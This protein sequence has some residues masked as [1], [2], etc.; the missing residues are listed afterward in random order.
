MIFASDMKNGGKSGMFV[1]L[2]VM[3]PKYRFNS[4]FTL[5]ELLVVIA[6]IAILAAMLLPALA[7][8]KERAK[9]IACA[10]NIRQYGLALRMYASDFNDKL[11]SGTISAADKAALGTTW[12]WDLGTNTATL[13]T[14][15]GSV[16][17]IL[18]DPAFSDQN[19]DALWTLSYTSGKS[20]VTGYAATFPDVALGGILGTNYNTTFL[21]AA[22]N[23][24]ERVLLACGTIKS[25]AGAYKG[26][27][28]ATSVLHSTAHM[29]GATPAGGNV[30]ML[31]NHVEWI[32]FNVMVV[33]AVGPN[34]AN[35]AGGSTSFFW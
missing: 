26:I 15:N 11:P 12:P 3:K 32:K 16:R 1:A 19:N 23:V 6:I 14:D 35:G 28:A 17:N 10:N 27:P 21:P 4:A 29:D 30:C 25:G 22:F 2:P 20:R 5:I 8:S 24:S 34:G 31:D 13:L 18:Y 7:K 9:R 33:R